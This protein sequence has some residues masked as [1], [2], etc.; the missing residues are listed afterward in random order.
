M[1]C[2]KIAYSKKGLG[3]LTALLFIVASW[4][5]GG[6]QNLDGRWVRHSAASL[7]SNNKE[8]QVEKIIDGNRYV[9]FSVRGSY[10][11]RTD[12]GN[13]AYGGIYANKMNLDPVQIFCYD[14][15]KEWSEDN[16][17]PLAQMV[18][19]SGNFH[20]IAEYSPEAGVLALVYRDN[21]ID[22]VF[23]DGT[24]VASKALK[25][26]SVPNTL[27]P[28]AV[29]FDKERQRIY[30]GCSIG[31][32]V[33]DYTN[34]EL[35]SMHKLPNPVSWVGRVGSNIVLFTGKV[36]DK[37][38]STST[39]I[40]PED[41][42]P[43]S[44]PTPVGNAANLQALMPLSDNSFAALAPGSSE[45]VNSLKLFTIG[46]TGAVSSE[47]LTATMTVDDASAWK[48]RHFFRTDG[49]VIPTRDGYGIHCKESVVTLRKGAPRAELMN[50]VPKTG[51]SA[52]EAASKSATFD[53]E[54]FWFY[55]YDN[56]GLSNEPKRGFYYRDNEN[57]TWGAK[58][59]VA[60]LSAP[61]TFIPIWGTWNPDL[62]IV[63]RGP[64]TYF[65]NADPD[66]DRISAYKDGKWTDLSFSAHNSK[67]IKPTT[68]AKF[69][70]VDPVNSD[71]I[72]G[73]YARAGL[74][75]IDRSNYDNFL[76][77][78]SK[79]YN[80]YPSQYPGY[81]TVFEPQNDVWG[82][83]MNVSDFDFDNKGNMWF[84]RYWMGK[85]RD[86]WFDEY[87]NARTP[88]YYLTPEERKA[89]ANIGSDQSKLPDILGRELCV[90]RGG[91]HFNSKLMACKAPANEN[92]LV[93]ALNMYKGRD[94]HMIVYDHNGTPADK[95]DDRYAFVDGL[96][97]EDGTPLIY[98]V[99]E[100]VYEDR[101]T[102]EIWILT[103]SGPYIF[104][105]SEFLDGKAIAR[106]PVVENTHGIAAEKNVLNQ[107]TIHN[108]ADD[109]Y[110]RKWV[111][112]EMGLYC[113]S[114][115]CKELLGHYTTENSPLLSDLV[116][117]VVCDGSNGAVFALTDEGII[118]FQPEGSTAS[119]SA[120]SHLSIWPSTL[121]PDYN[122]Y[123]N[124][125]G[126]VGG[127][128]YGIYDASGSRVKTLG[129][130]RDG[131]FQWDGKSDSGVKVEKGRYSIKRSGVEESHPIIV[132]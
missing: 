16:I 93:I 36:S 106:M 19:L 77:I 95:T 113:L 85:D 79:Y 130:P 22:F 115:D 29:T 104:N 33:I 51:L 46:T 101:N 117:N 94:M 120:A 9:Y 32:A 87:E 114:A 30:L 123:I 4:L 31:F 40:V 12:N 43:A 81:F 42:I 119:I 54:R 126:A 82:I 41:K 65:E 52:T 97:N 10:W 109:I 91:I 50:V 15:R 92:Y 35:V 62:G 108:I 74:F 68:A 89:M 132:L 48:S 103:D 38:Y 118:E 25:D 105:P 88:I 124:I 14:K 110:G 55:T 53:G 59:E 20:H 116:Y 107:I 128:N 72:W 61:T 24:V 122:G 129:T 27:I 47:T 49:F 86:T 64:G 7:R 6:A 76:Q 18:E 1:I 131:A 45:T 26:A 39:Y 56:N 127:A 23:D 17:R 84:A 78:G 21:M 3:F 99:E 102:G 28:Y 8:G 125:T 67:Y 13:D 90:Y 83:V 69:V 66:I 44:L 57:A 73:S 98:M 121:T 11:G 96:Y 37:E 75:R 60:A 112:S 100:G 5:P 63:V 58:S 70:A 80:N 34:G 71:W 111:A 2:K